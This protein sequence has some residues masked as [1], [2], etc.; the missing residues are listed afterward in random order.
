MKNPVIIK[1]DKGGIHIIIDPDAILTDVLLQLEL[2]LQG[3]SSIYR[4]SKPINVT[5]DGKALTEDEKRDILIILDK[6]GLNVCLSENKH[7]NTKQQNIRDNLS[8]ILSDKDGLFYIGNLKNG[9]SIDAMCSIVIIGNVE[10]GASVYSCGNIVIT[11][12]LEG[13]AQAGCTGREDA[14]VYSLISG[15]NI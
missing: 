10:K 12:S 4:N 7:K 3:T 13:I 5:F 8:N 15:R 9:Q 2:K 11:G 1:G 14:F 6:L